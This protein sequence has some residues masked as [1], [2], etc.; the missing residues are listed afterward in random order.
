MDPLP[1]HARGELTDAEAVEMRQ[2]LAEL[3]ETGPGPA[4]EVTPQELSPVAEAPVEDA[5]LA[6]LD[7]ILEQL[8]GAKT[9]D[10]VRR[11]MIPQEWGAILRRSAVPRW[12][13][14]RLFLQV[15]ALGVTTDPRAAYDELLTRPEVEPISPPGSGPDASRWRVRWDH[16]NAYL[17]EWI[18]PATGQSSAEFLALARRLADYHAAGPGRDSLEWLYHTAVINPQRVRQEFDSQFK[19]AEAEFDLPQCHALVTLFDDER[20]ISAELVRARDERRLRLDARSFWADEYYRTVCYFRRV[21]LEHG[22]EDV[23]TGTGGRWILHVHGGGGLGKT[24]FVRWAIAR[25][26]VPRGIPCATVDLGVLK[27]AD[28]ASEPGQV[29]VAFARQIARQV[30][31][32]RDPLEKLVGDLEKSRR[33]ADSA[34]PTSEGAPKE[35]RWK[36][37]DAHRKFGSALGPALDCGRVLLVLDTL[38]HAVVASGTA[39]AQLLRTLDEVRRRHCPGLRLLLTGR[40]DF[41]EVIDG[42]ERVPGFREEFGTATLTTALKRFTPTEARK[43]LADSRGLA[44]DPRVR[45][46]VSLFK[47]ERRPDGRPQRDRRFINP[48]QLA[49]LGDL[50]QSDPDGK[51]T[52]DELRRNGVEMQ[53]LLDRILL[54]IP[55]SMRWVL[56]FG[57]I[58]RVLTREFL[59]VVLVP[60]LKEVIARRGPTA[61]QNK[62]LP[63]PV[64]E[65]KALELPPEE[66]DPG[67][68]DVDTLWERL[69]K[70]ASESSWVDR[71]RGD[72]GAVEFHPNARNP[73]LRLA[74]ANVGDFLRL[75]REALDFFERQAHDRPDR[76]A[77]ATAEAVYHR[78]QLREGSGAVDYWRDRL[79]EAERRGRSDWRRDLASDL[80]GPD[81]VDENLRPLAA[82]DGTSVVS[83]EVVAEACYQQA[84]ACVAVFLGTDSPRVQRSARSAAQEAGR[85][86]DRLRRDTPGAVPQLRHAVLRIG[87]VRIG[88]EKGDPSEQIERAYRDL[89]SGADA[90]DL[91]QIELLWAEHAARDGRPEGVDQ[92][93]DVIRRAEANPDWLTDDRLTR[94][95]QIRL[96]G[97]IVGRD[98]PRAVAALADLRAHATTA[99]DR[100]RVTA[101]ETR[102]AIMGGEFGEVLRTADEAARPRRPADGYSQFLLVRLNAAQATLEQ[103]DP[104]ECRRRCEQLQGLIDRFATRD[105]SAA[106]ERDWVAALTAELRCRRHFALY[107]F[108]AGE[109]EMDRALDLYER[110]GADWRIH[111]A[112]QRKI[113]AQLRDVGSL[114]GA[115]ERL[116]SRTTQAHAPNPMD[117]FAYQLLRSE[118]EQFRG[119]T[120]EADRLLEE[121]W[122]NADPDRD[123]PWQTIAVCTQA[124]TLLIDQEAYRGALVTALVRMQPN[125]RWGY[126]RELG[127]CRPLAQPLTDHEQ[128]SL[129]L[130]AADDLPP[131]DRAIGDL[132]EA[133]FW[134]VFGRPKVAADRLRAAAG[135]L[136]A[137]DRT[138]FPLRRLFQAWD[139]LAVECGPPP[140]EWYDRITF[141]LEEFAGQQGFCGAF[142]QERAEALR[143]RDVQGARHWHAEAGRYLR[144][145]QDGSWWPRRWEELGARLDAS[146]RHDSPQVFAS[147]VESITANVINTGTGGSGAADPLAPTNPTVGLSLELTPAGLSCRL[148]GPG[149]D[150]APADI[151]YVPDLPPLGGPGAVSPTSYAIADRLADPGA[152]FWTFAGNWIV[153]AARPPAGPRP[154]DAPDLRIVGDP[155]AHALPWEAAIE[156]ADHPPGSLRHVY[157]SAEHTRPD[158][159]LIRWVQQALNLVR[160]T[161]LKVTGVWDEPSRQALSSFQHDASLP[162]ASGLPNA[163]TRAELD[164][165]L[166]R[167]G[168]PRAVVLIVARRELLQPLPLQFILTLVGH[169]RSVGFEP[170][171]ADPTWEGI[172]PARER[173][174]SIVHLIGQVE[175]SADDL[176]LVFDGPGVPVHPLLASAV[177]ESVESQFRVSVSTLTS[178]I[179]PLAIKGPRPVVVIHAVPAT[180]SPIEY[181]QQVLLRNSFAARLFHLGAAQAVVITGSPF[182]R[183]EPG[184]EVTAFVEEPDRLRT[185]GEMLRVLRVWTARGATPAPFRW[186]V[187]LQQT[188]SALFAH[189]PDIAPPSAGRLPEP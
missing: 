26:A 95:R 108:E 7:P 57:V 35:L 111:R 158:T 147:G 47:P 184:P 52:I 83:P 70:Y 53:Y 6:D 30:P 50:L 36:D 81:Y 65:K 98:L 121:V 55:F 151:L 145:L 22:L 79:R 115:L 154:L 102:V 18:D 172:G 182:D 93:G 9:A 21:E 72:A 125:V 59:G 118:A 170:V 58:P 82:W 180:A 144:T 178:L 46:V 61:E 106:N 42:E 160:R 123:P 20:P 25:F 126:H 165:Q 27:F 54:Q 77:A 97:A 120:A 114:E 181:V 127:R 128:R 51:I 13:D 129:A 124:L 87:L 187:A 134:R 69:T 10:D 74:Q 137:H 73:T 23:V 185:V 37:D 8:R 56:V 94:L 44:D 104:A 174:C 171:L 96:D 71:V 33:R 39:M 164:R 130:P 149:P 142:L 32:A 84:D 41:A 150:Q 162:G 133:E 75:H 119:H 112:R 116:N 89:R 188:A 186:V 4:A 156:P 122:R 109:R 189:D 101:Q 173:G 66:K 68:Q 1:A 86:L 140:A 63:A 80:R 2:L 85:Q 60:A 110:L 34:T 135:V 14:R 146:G 17:R 64:R 143:D 179:H 45:D 48:L 169:Y 29:W 78:F 139:R 175:E 11:A 168:V 40:Y 28:L 132:Y 141:F 167:A 105:Q 183:R 107:E 177:R 131:R 38:E 176:S 12:F 16:R 161:V 153:D 5:G 159:D 88:A 113:A 103:L 67:P 148:T 62:A 24:M 49:L 91:F 166:V 152:S 100:M 157:R 15:I 90:R 117:Q 138:V 43:Y 76:W 31:A 3:Q 163:A 99:E 19:R 136:L 92:L 155:Y